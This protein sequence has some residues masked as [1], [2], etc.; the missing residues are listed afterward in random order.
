MEKKA[1]FYE[2]LADDKIKCVLCSHNCIILEGKR[3][4]CGVRENKNGELYSLVYGK[5]IARNIDP[6]EK[7]PFFH[8]MPGSF[9]YSIGTVGCNFKCL[10]CQNF[11]ISQEKRIIGVDVTCD[12]VVDE[13]LWHDCSSIAYTY[14]EPTI[15]YEFVLDCA[16]LARSKGLKNVFITNGYMSKEAFLKIAPYIDAVN[17]DLKFFSDENYKKVASAKLQPVLDFI[18]LVHSKKIHLEITTLVIPTINDGEDELRKIAK[19][20]SSVDKNIPWHISAFYPMYKLTHLS[21][22]SV[23]ILK[24]AYDIGKEEGINFVYVANVSGISSD[25]ICPE[26]GK[27]IIKRHGYRILDLGTDG[28]GNCKYCKTK[29]L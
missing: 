25:T 17:I 7:K 13:A 1:L 5:I 26:C 9:A 23:L 8:F 16:K 6:I 10:N 29:M 20:I 12:E 24:R 28:K 11:D 4:I 15:F 3:G 14:N 18:K 19:F 2:K 22:T 21:A 27:I